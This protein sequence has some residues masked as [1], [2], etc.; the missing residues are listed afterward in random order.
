LFICPSQWKEPLARVHYE[1]MAAGLP[2][3]T[4]D[5]G[6][7]S[8]LFQHGIDA[9]IIKNYKE[10]KAF[11]K[12]ITTLLENPELAKKMGRLGRKKVEKTYNFEHVTNDLE[13]IYRTLGKLK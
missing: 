6:G 5:R 10:P 1:A 7:N 4:T 13:L 3:I 2:I 11:V 8:E 12:A 9:M